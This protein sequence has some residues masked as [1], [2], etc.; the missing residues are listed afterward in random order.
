MEDLG[1]LVIFG[2]ANDK[3]LFE[4]INKEYPDISNVADKKGFGAEQWTELSIVLIGAVAQSVFPILVRWL[5]H[6][7]SKRAKDKKASIVLKNGKQETVIRLSEF[8]DLTIEKIEMIAGEKSLLIEKL[9]IKNR[10]K[11]NAET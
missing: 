7:L 2:D 9:C 6:C 5:S 10:D 1:K 3:D 8:Q 11:E 4:E